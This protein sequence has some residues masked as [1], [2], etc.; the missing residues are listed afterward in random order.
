MQT[1]SSSLPSD[2]VLLE[3]MY[4]FARSFGLQMSMLP[5]QRVEDGDRLLSGTGVTDGQVSRLTRYDDA[6]GRGA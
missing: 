2:L 3:E 6:L 4:N 1:A 5:E